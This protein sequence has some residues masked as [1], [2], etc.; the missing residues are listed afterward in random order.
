[1]KPNKNK[2]D[3]CDFHNIICN[4]CC[5]RDVCRFVELVFELKFL[6]ISGC[7]EYRK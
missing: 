6:D 7:K 2:M 4:D 5:K 3:A 1:M